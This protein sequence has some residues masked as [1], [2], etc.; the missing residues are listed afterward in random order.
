ML[1]GSR[2]DA[3]GTELGSFVVERI[4]VKVG[5]VSG[6]ARL[7]T[8]SAEGRAGSRARCPAVRHRSVVGR[9]R[10]PQL[11]IVEYEHERG[12]PHRRRPGWHRQTPPG[13][14]VEVAIPAA[15]GAERHVH[16][17]AERPA[18]TGRKVGQADRLGSDVAADGSITQPS[19]PAAGAV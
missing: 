19:R 5:T 12:H 7:C 14:G 2:G 8:A 16:V 10:P 1:R 17:H 15:G 4:T 9:G 18:R 6:L 11:R 3:A 13:I